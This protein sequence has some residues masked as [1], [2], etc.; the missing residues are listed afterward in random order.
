M[1]IASYLL[2]AGLTTYA[3]TDR[4]SITGT[5]SDP[6][7][8]VVASAPIEARNIDTGQVFA[9][10]ATAT[11]NYTIPQLPPGP[12]ELAVTVPGFKKYERKG[13]VVSPTQVMRIDITLEV[14]SAA[15]SVT[16]TAEAPLLATE[17]GALTHNVTATQLTTL[18][19]LA[20]GGVGSTATSGFRDPFALARLIPGINYIA[21]SQMVINGNP[22]DTMQIRVEGQVAGN[23]GGLRQYTGQTQPSVDA[24]QEVAVQTSNY[25]AEF[26]TVGGGIFNV[27]MKSGTNQYHG[28]AYDFMVNDFLN[29]AT[30]FL[31]QK[32]TQRR[33]DYGGTVGG[34]LAIPKLYDGRNRTFFFWNF[35]QFRENLGVRTSVVTVPAPAYRQ[36]DF[37]RVIIGSG[38]DG[39]PLPLQVGGRDYV[40]PVG[41]SYMS[42]TIF[43]P[44]TERTVISGGQ[45]ILVRDPFPGNLVPAGRFDP[46]AVKVQALV[47]LPVGARANE[48]GGNFN[49]PWVSHRTSELPS[50]KMDQN[51]GSRGKLSFYWQKT[52]TTSQYSFPN[53]N[54]EG[55]PE[56]ITVARGT[57][58]YTKTIRLNYD[59]TLA[60]TL[61]AHFGVGYFSNNFD[62]HSPVTNYDAVKEL[63]LRGATLNRTF[64]QF[65]VGASTATGGMSN[66]GTGVQ[67]NSLEQRPSANTSFTWIKNN[68]SYKIGGEW[69]QEGYLNY[70]FTNVSGSYNFAAAATAQTSLQGIAISQGSLGFG[71]ASFLL[72]LTNS[73]TLA[74]NTALK[75]GKSQWALF[76]QDTWKVTR[77]F[78]LDYGLRWDL[79][80]YAREQYGRNGN[81]NLF[82]PN[83]SAGGHPGGWVFEATCACQFSSAY[84]YAIGP[85]ISIA[86]QITPKTVV[87]TGY[88]IVYN[89]TSIAAGS[90]SNT[91]TTGANGFAQWNFQL[92]GGMPSSVDPQWPTFNPGQSPLPNTVAAAPVFLDP[93]ATRPARQMQWSVGLQ[94]EIHRNLAVE[95]SYVANRGVW[96]PAAGL[97]AVN[98][99]SEPLLAKYGFT[100]GNLADSTLLAKQWGQLN[101]ADRTVLAARGVGLPYAGF[102]TNQTILQSLRP[103]PQYN[104]LINPSA[105]PLGNTWYDSLQVTVTQRYW[106]GLTANANYT[107]SKTLELMSSPDIFNRQ[108]GKSRPGTDLPHILRFSAE[109]QVARNVLGGNARQA[110][111]GKFL[112]YILSDWNLGVYLQYQSAPLLGLPTASTNPALTNW[113]G[114]GPGSAERIPGQS[115][116]ATTWTDYDGK[117]HTNEPI[118]LNCHCYDPNRTV[119]LN[120]AAWQ[121]PAVGRWSAAAQNYG[122]FRGFRWPQENVNL[123]RTFR[124][125]ERVSFNI[126]ADFSN[127]FNRTRL[128]NP[129]LGSFTSRPQTNLEG[130]YT[131]GF[132]TVVTQ[133]PP[134]LSRNGI[135]VGRITF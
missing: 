31:N 28:T 92:N 16:V 86:W 15:E 20:L 50:L 57:F 6:A 65:S 47:P 83:P 71:Y 29:A 21:N 103:F 91:Q 56:P 127:I 113:L 49:N 109:Y 37:S 5:I 13:L 27:S 123:G 67:V 46:V 39:V 105:A 55:F 18:P 130:V 128:P 34:P 66:I 93:N 121:N 90:V 96:W 99:I 88:G 8:A 76:V 110:F 85:R 118:N 19:I 112:S 30:P 129:N 58:I 52:G 63:G 84:P 61:L 35:E 54:M 107:F 115:L 26:G 62:D 125:S 98:A 59:H 44:R 117:V 73:G 24:I 97:S 3:Q 133:N 12:Y 42:G 102:P 22:D 75:T 78:T 36:G 94:R 126:R 11:G 23:T 17:S 68:H 101:A 106:H 2:L 40:D 104:T 53:G 25:S 48:L 32:S 64:P 45:N 41:R 69:R 77:K 135:I 87:R 114:R 10:S 132:G 122:D 100:V 111:G 131:G 43:D 74:R 82:T 38:R 79:G 9:A 95:A 119:V 33:H 7:G 124:I 134:L 81:L 80:T 120:P 51:I 108:L 14:G 1:R 60:P 89:S 72:G 116:W 4:G 70:G